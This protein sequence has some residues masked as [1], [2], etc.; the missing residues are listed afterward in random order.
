MKCDETLPRCYKCVSTGR[1]CDGYGPDPQGLVEICSVSPSPTRLLCPGIQGTAKE[2]RCFYF[3]QT[4]TAP[5]LSTFLGSDFW[6]TILLQSAL[7]EPSIRHA[8]IALGSLHETSDV[9]N[10]LIARRHISRYIDDFA[11][12]NYN[13]A[14]N[15]LIGPSAKSS[16]ATY[17]VCVICSILFACLEVCASPSQRHAH[18]ASI[19]NAKQLRLRYYPCTERDEDPQRA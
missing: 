9:D 12:K 3:F 1:T 2:R 15:L 6:N 8:V 14:I 10:N 5:Q 17:D 18:S 4:K 19:D 7:R 11:L 16:M 13:Q